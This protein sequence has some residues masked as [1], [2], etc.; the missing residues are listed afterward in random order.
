MK[1]LHLQWMWLCGCLQQ[2]P[3][4]VEHVSQNITR[5]GLTSY[6]LN[7]LRVRMLYCLIFGK[8]RIASFPHWSRSFA[9][10]EGP[11]D[12]RCQSKSWRM[13]HSCMKNTFERLAVGNDLEGDSRSSEL[14][15]FDRPYI[16]SYWWSI[17]RTTIWHHCR[18][19]L[20]CDM[21]CI[22]II[23]K[24]FLEPFSLVVSS[25]TRRVN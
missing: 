8:N 5:Q 14:P 11:C 13:L 24:G 15:L 18:E 4:F 16:T 6:T 20:P 25:Y 2:E 19:I 3:S 1:Q 22:S 7:F 12:A 17:V 23:S 10:A 9:I 21:W